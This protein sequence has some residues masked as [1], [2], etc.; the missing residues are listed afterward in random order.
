MTP[1]SEFLLSKHNKSLNTYKVEQDMKKEDFTEYLLSLGF[2]MTSTKK[3][4]C[5]K[6][7][8]IYV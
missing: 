1:I 7:K 4:I 3:R 8:R 6:Q 2:Y 5:E